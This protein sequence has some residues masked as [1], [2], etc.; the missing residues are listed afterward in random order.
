MSEHKIVD[1]T[2]APQGPRYATLPP[3]DVAEIHGV[4]A[5]YGRYYDDG[6]LD[7]FMGLIA[8]DAVFY[9]NWPG[10]LPEVVE[11]APALRALFDAAYHGPVDKGGLPRH[12]ATNMLIVR[13]A[14]DTAEATVAMHYYEKFPGKPPE[15]LMIGQYD[16]HLAKRAGRW[17]ITCWAMRY[18]L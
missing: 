3:E 16:F 7:D 9:P 8:D 13:A 4:L 5:A 18:D 6:A 10:V 11:G 12:A 2:P 1:A 17:I 14:A 15:L